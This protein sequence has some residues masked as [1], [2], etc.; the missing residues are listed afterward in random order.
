M[1]EESIKQKKG[2]LIVL[3]SPS[4][5]GKTTVARK[6][7]EKDSNLILSISYTTRPP[8]GEERNGIDY[9]FVD[10]ETFLQMKSADKFMEW[11]MVFG[12]YYGTSRDFVEE[13]LFSGRDILL[14]IDVQGGRQIK[15]DC[16]DS[17]LIFLLPP[18]MEELERRLK[19]RKTETEEKIRN[20]LKVASWEVEQGENYDYL[21]VNDKLDKACNEILCIIRAERAKID[22]RKE[23]LRSWI[24]P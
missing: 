8:R 9:F 3:S 18:S 12:E 23:L 11:A 1:P 5:A 22:R 20:R 19:R 21:V 14:R 16:Q 10:E 24:S 17:V 7:I 4:G 15:A 6:L 2:L 13:H